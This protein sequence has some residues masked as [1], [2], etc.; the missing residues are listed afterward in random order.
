MLYEIRKENILSASKMSQNETPHQIEG[1]DIIKYPWNDNVHNLDPENNNDKRI[2]NWNLKK[3]Q[4]EGN[5]V[6]QPSIGNYL[7]CLS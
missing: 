2:D 7:C 5:F 3:V 1:Q 4:L 6:M